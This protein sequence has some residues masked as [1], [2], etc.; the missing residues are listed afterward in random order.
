MTPITATRPATDDYTTFCEGVRSL[1]KVVAASALLAAVSYGVWYGL[2]RALGRSGIAQLG[3]VS[4]ALA[5]G[6]AA[7][8]LAARAL[9]SPEIAALHSLRGRFRKA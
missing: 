5:A 6:G 1:A 7:Y 2:D 8:L 9:G 4:L 3:A